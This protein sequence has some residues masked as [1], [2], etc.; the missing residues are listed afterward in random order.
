MFNIHVLW[1]LARAARREI[2]G[3]FSVSYS[4]KVI[5][6]ESGGHLLALRAVNHVCILHIPRVRTSPARTPPLP[7]P[8]HTDA[9]MDRTSHKC[10]GAQHAQGDVCAWGDVCGGV[11]RIP[12]PPHPTQTTP[13]LRQWGHAS[14][15]AYTVLDKTSRHEQLH[16]AP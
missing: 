14:K 9:G 7:S 4:K 3:V 6:N 16:R 1:K 2:F 12:T 10:T 13:C 8:A 5:H 15:P 11:C